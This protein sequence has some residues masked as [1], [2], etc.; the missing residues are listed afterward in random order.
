MSPPATASN[1]WKDLVNGGVLQCIEAA[2]LGMPFE[3]WKTRMG[4]FRTESSLESF[5][6]VYRRGGVTAFWQG[7]TPKLVE[8]ATKGAVLLYSKEMIFDGMTKLGYNETAAGFVAG[9]GGG[10]C[11]TVVMSP[12]T[13]VVTGMVTGANKDVTV[14]AKIRDTYATHGLRGFYSGASAVAFRQA[15]NWASRQGLTEYVRSQIKKHKYD[16][17][18]SARL[19][20]ADEAMAGTV[21]GALSTWNQPF[22]VARITMQSNTNEGGKPRGLTKT[23][24]VIA[25][26]DGVMSLYKGIVPRVFLG[27]W[28]TLFMVTGAKLIRQYLPW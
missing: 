8:S 3:V 1:G 15:T 11:Q 6:N 16:G 28:Q 21:G 7:C 25:K 13:F 2:T 20:V 9:A 26:N 24:L 18:S 22:E 4:R 27:I 19:S 5:A 23:M 12:C 10:V 17:D 14:G